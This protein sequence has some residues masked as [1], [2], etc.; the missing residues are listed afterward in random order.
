MSTSEHVFGSVKRWM[1]SG[2]LLCKG[3]VAAEAENSLSFLAYNMKRIISLG[4]MKQLMCKF[5]LK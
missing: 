1:N 2:F 5:A 4:K 3:K